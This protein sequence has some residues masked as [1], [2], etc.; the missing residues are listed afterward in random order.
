MN[1]PDQGCFGALGDLRAALTLARKLLET[2]RR[3]GWVDALDAVYRFLDTLDP[4][5]QAARRS[6][7]QHR[8]QRYWTLTMERSIRAC[9][10]QNAAAVVARRTGTM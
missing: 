6:L 2:D 3:Q 1:K 9:G 7:L 8:W 4:M 5:T 10:R